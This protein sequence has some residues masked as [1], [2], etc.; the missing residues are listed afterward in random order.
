LYK[1]QARNVENCDH[2]LD[3]LSTTYKRSIKLTVVSQ[4]IHINL[5]LLPDK[6]KSVIYISS[7]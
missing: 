6:V 5:K 2:K 3:V 7:A 4:I 1:T